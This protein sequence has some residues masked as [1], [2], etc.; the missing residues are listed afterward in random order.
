M[1]INEI[2]SSSIITKSNLPDSNYVINPYV[3]CSHKCIYCY[4]RFM[5]RF[6][7]HTENRWDFVD[8][9]T[10]ADD[11]IPEDTKKYANK[12]IF[13]SSVTDPYLHLERKYKLTRKILKKLLS[14]NPQLWIQTKSDLIIR[15]IDILKQFKSC[16][17]WITI[18]TT[19]D[20][21]RKEIE[22]FTA[23]ISDRIK[24]LRELKK[25]WIKTYVFIWPIMPFFTD[26][27]QIILK[28]KDFV[29]FYMFENLNIKWWIRNNIKNWLQ[30]NHTDVLKDFEKIYFQKNNYWENVENEIKTF[31]EKEN[32]IYKIFF[33]HW[34]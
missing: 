25:W 16:E 17:V 23:S 22:P 21:I 28:T 27:K 1:Q 33:H 8:I 31:C 2:K 20:N 19:N 30:T 10:N 29:D 24:T 12:S 6:T 14:L 26:W 11:L 5:K 3:W 4:A 15:D 13:M 7:K 9:K 34:K 32:I 18:T